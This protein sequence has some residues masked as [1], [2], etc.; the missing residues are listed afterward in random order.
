MVTRIK[1]PMYKT[2]CILFPL[3]LM[4]SVTGCKTGPKEGSTSMNQEF[5][6]AV[7]KLDTENDK[8]ID[9][10]AA[11]MKQE[12]WQKTRDVVGL[13]HG[14]DPNDS[15]R[16][17]ALVLSTGSLALSPLL[18]SLPSDNPDKLV[19]DLQASLDMHFGN[20]ALIVSRLQEML[21]DKR[22]LT[23]PVYPPHVEEKPVPRRVCDEAYLMLR[24]LLSGEDAEAEMLNSREFINGMS[25]PKRDEI[26][27]G[28]LKTKRWQSLLQSASEHQTFE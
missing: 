19:W 12:A 2:W 3:A 17:R 11:G 6:N 20:Q 27:E 14:A 13:L 8:Q 18:D 16:A 21:Q 10:L 4:V 5:V 7:K 1:P 22:P 15:K 25:D 26:I 28:F 24:K 23:L 9:S